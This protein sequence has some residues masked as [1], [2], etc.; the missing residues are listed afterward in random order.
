MGYERYVLST[1]TPPSPFEGDYDSGHV[2][3]LDCT[4]SLVLHDF[5]RCTVLAGHAISSMSCHHATLFACTP[6]ISRIYNFSQV[7]LKYTI[8]MSHSKS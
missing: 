7:I 3:L 1:L 8:G 6:F 4:L 2:L 5:G